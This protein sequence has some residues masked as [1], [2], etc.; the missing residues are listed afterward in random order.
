MP[1]YEYDCATCGGFAATRPMAE[2]ADPQPCPGCG[3]LAE[4]ALTVP[5]LGAG[6]SAPADTSSWAPS[7]GSSHF[8]GCSCCSGRSTG[9]RADAVAA[10]SG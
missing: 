3:A 6:T 1:R 5:S 2:F 9:F 4:R 8:G 7:G 10:G